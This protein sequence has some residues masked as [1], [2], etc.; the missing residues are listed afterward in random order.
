MSEHYLKALFEPRAVVLVGATGEGQVGARVLD[1]LVAG[2][3]KGALFAVDPARASI[4]GVACVASVGALPQPVDLAVIATPATAVAGAV[5][6]CAR[7]GIRA[8][9]VISAGFRDAGPEGAALESELLGVARRNGVRLL[10]PDCMGVMR[11]PLGLNATVARG[12]ALPGALALVS[13]S[14]TLCSA[15]LDWATSV[16]V[17]FSSVISLGGST[18]I[19]F[20][21]VIDYLASDFQTSHIL[22]YAEGV[23]D[24][25]R[26]VSSLRAAA[27]AKPVIVMKVGRHPAGSRAAVSHSGAA[28]GRDDVFDAVVKRTGVVRVN[29]AGEMVAA[30]LAL[31]SKVRPR[32]ERLAVITNGGGPGVM[33]TDRAAEL[34]LPLA[35]LSPATIDSLKRALPPNWS[36]GN[37]VD[38]MGDAGADRYSAAVSACLADAGVDGAIVIL[39]PEAMTDAEAAARAVID[40][41]A[42]SSKPVIGCWMGGASVAGARALL[43]RA[44]LSTYR[45]PETA[46]EAFATLAR[47]YRNQRLLLEAPP[48]LAHQ[49][50]PD[51]AAARAMVSAALAHG[52]HVLGATESKAF[53][54]AFRIPTVRSIDVD[55]AEEAVTASAAV[56]YPVVMKIRSP[57]LTRKSD[58]G[59]VRLG[60]ADGAAVRAAYEEMTGE[61]ARSRPDARV[62]G[63]S[64]ERVAS[65]AHGRELMVGLASDAVFGPA[66]RFGAGGIAAEL[67]GDSSVGLPPLNALLAGEL[68]DATRVARTLEAFGR[69]PAI[70]R[71]PLIDVL[72]RISEMACEIPELVALDVNPLVADEN[73][74]LALDARVVLR[75]ARPGLV[76]YSHLAIH[77]YPVELEGE[78]VFADGTSLRVRPIRPEDAALEQAFVEGLSPDSGRMRFQS[79]L[80]TLSPA[81]LARFTQIDYDREMALVAIDT[82][83][84]AE[85]QVAV[86][87]YIRLP[88]EASCEYAIVL[89]DDW[90]GRGLGSRLMTRLI[91]IARSRGL[92]TMIGW[93]LASNPGML[94][95]CSRLGFTDEPVPGDS[96]L[97]L[98]TLRL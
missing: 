42:G 51:L 59:G 7:A 88:D 20:G 37:P 10:G 62:E 30:A 38:L 68:I 4:R 52:R 34:G 36:D 61:V 55:G 57:D 71:A 85:R 40:A 84:T 67:L 75:E 3:F 9:V 44:G 76:R 80:R 13:Q 25:R 32:G 97:R 17:G 19:D 43:R 86:C 93:V 14:G 92:A 45:L 29:T 79:A 50:P 90:Q 87:R 16:G 33:A 27:R 95:V 54:E 39:A 81:M 48:P 77:P 35:D 46:V 58:V 56:G 49:I 22:V 53:L 23:R 47:F 89:A 41:A 98:V 65:S 60:L 2:G 24:G 74:V 18:D 11:T 69:L 26:L 66:I 72:L 21:E 28:V 82:S 12:P 1:N 70:D 73:G 5:E 94:H 96:H 6:E 15:M 64:I 83:G 31:A 8:A 78:E 63:V 91:A